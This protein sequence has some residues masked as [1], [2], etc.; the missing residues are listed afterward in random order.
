MAKGEGTMD[1]ERLEAEL[2]A[3][4]EAYRN[5]ADL[6]AARPFGLHKTAPAMEAELLA[7]EKA[8]GASLPPGLRAFFSDYSGRLEFF[9]Y[10]NDSFCRTLPGALRGIFCASLRLGVAEVVAVERSRRAWVERCFSDAAAPYDR[11]WHGKLGLLRVANGDIVALDLCDGQPDHS[12][13]YLSHDDGEGHGCLLGRSFAAFLENYAAV[14]LCGE[15]DW[16]ML[17]FIP[18]ATT[19]ICPDCDNAV[20]YR[21]LVCGVGG[22]CA[23]RLVPK[24]SLSSELKS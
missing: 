16:Q 2:L 13:V 22:V 23:R 14:G 20:F 7:A 6:G 21:K 8:L 3:W 18:D 9:A 11:V 10:L 4:Q 12:V 15:E 5:I 19:G 17:P 24:V 1:Y